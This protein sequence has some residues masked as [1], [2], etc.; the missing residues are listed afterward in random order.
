MKLSDAIR[1][2]AMLG[3]QI[4]GQ[5][6]DHA[7]TCALGAAAVA[8]G[9]GVGARSIS[10]CISETWPWVHTTFAISPDCAIC[11][12]TRVDSIILHLND[13]AKWTREEIADWVATVEPQDAPA[14][15]LVT[16]ERG[17]TC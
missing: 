13:D 8:V 7:G 6:A 1:L 4:R 2:G 14:P 10:D 15:E 17:A 11:H 5:Y 3:P 16:V 12:P 9:A